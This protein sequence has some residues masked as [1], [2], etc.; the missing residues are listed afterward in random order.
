MSLNYKMVLIS[1]S[2]IQ[3]YTEYIFKK[4]VTLTSIPPIHVYLNRINNRLLFKIKDG[5]MLKLQMPETVKLFGSTKTLIDKTKNEEN[6]PSSS[7]QV[8]LV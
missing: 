5:Y 2:D 3:D 6:I 1:V 7:I 4:L 8:V